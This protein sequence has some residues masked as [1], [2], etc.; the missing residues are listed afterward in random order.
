[1]ASETSKPN[2]GL[3]NKLKSLFYRVDS[4]L[5]LIIFISF[6][7]NISSALGY[8]TGTEL[9]KALIGDAAVFYFVRNLAT[10][11]GNLSAFLCGM[12]GDKANTRKTFI[13]IGYSGVLVCKFLYIIA[14]YKGFNTIIRRF[15]FVLAI[16]FERFLSSIR[17]GPRNI[18]VHDN[19]RYKNYPIEEEKE[20]VSRVFGIRKGLS[21]LGSVIGGLIAYFVYTIFKCE[22]TTVFCLSFFFLSISVVTLYYVKDYG[23]LNFN[24]K[25]Y[26][27]AIK[28]NLY[29]FSKSLIT[30]CKFIFKYISLIVLILYFMDNNI[31][32]FVKNNTILSLLSFVILIFDIF[33]MENKYN[34]IVPLILFVFNIYNY[35]IGNEINILLPAI[36]NLLIDF[37]INDLSDI[38]YLPFYLIAIII[39]IIYKLKYLNYIPVNF[40]CYTIVILGHYFNNK[41][42]KKIDHFLFILVLDHFL[43][44][45]SLDH[46]NSYLALVNIFFLLIN[47]FINK[48]KKEGIKCFII[49]SITTLVF[50]NTNDIRSRLLLNII[51]LF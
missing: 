10:V 51:E 11:T 40:I 12:I 18:M 46:V 30:Y 7:T 9:S 25:E 43:S 17:D 27:P 32:D 47:I 49:N 5:W 42:I 15:F 31:I 36:I 28:E 6:T 3:L 8:S 35:F 26:I 50:Y 41:S 45:L 33:R 24:Y 2:R 1:M 44:L 34:K 22:L 29:S 38:K 37:N 20:L 4:N 19:V 39:N 48:S 13:I 14:S 16:L 23:N 21:A